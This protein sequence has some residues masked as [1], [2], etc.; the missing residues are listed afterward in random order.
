MENGLSGRGLAEEEVVE[1][2]VET[3]ELAG[4]DYCGE[5]AGHVY[6]VYVHDTQGAVCK[7][8][9]QGDDRD[10]GH[11]VAVAD[12][13]LDGLG[14]A[15]FNDHIEIIY[16]ETVLAERIFDN[17]PGAGAFLTQDKRDS[18]KLVH[19]DRVHGRIPAMSS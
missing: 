2:G 18:A 10:N 9:V 7:L 19:S 17:L 13:G 5:L 8:A 4:A 11:G 3:G 12:I 15:E 16:T 6:A 1:A 14:A